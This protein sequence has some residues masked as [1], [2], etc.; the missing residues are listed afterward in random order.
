MEFMGLMGLITAFGVLAAW[1][2]RPSNAAAS[3]RSGTTS[4]FAIPSL[5]DAGGRL[6]GRTGGGGGRSTGDKSRSSA[7]SVAPWRNGDHAAGRAIRTRPRMASPSRI[8]ST[9]PASSPQTSS[10]TPA[11]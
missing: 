2:T 9:S 7:L 5:P 3:A 8:G 6:A 10:P 11:T 4:A 1:A